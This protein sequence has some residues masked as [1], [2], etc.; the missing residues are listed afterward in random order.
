MTVSRLPSPLFP[1]LTFPISQH[2]TSSGRASDA[3][4]SRIFLYGPNSTFLRP[5]AWILKDTRIRQYS[6]TGGNWSEAKTSV[7]LSGFYSAWVHPSIIATKM[8]TSGLST[9]S[10]K[11]SVPPNLSAPI[12]RAFKVGF[13]LISSA[14]LA[15]T[16][17]FSASFVVGLV[18]SSCFRSCWISAAASA[19]FGWAA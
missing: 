3:T 4:L 11:A 10:L 8:L 5:G 19:K 18:S 15:T 17:S 2:W 12:T 6:C 7:A 13:F 9:A 1:S 14:A 16:V